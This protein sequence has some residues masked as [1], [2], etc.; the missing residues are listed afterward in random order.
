MKGLP[1]VLFDC[2][3]LLRKPETSAPAIVMSMCLSREVVAGNASWTCS[4]RMTSCMDWVEVVAE[5][6]LKNVSR[7]AVMK[8][9]ESFKGATWASKA[10]RR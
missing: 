1:G 6:C 9:E 7:L 10:V 2:L 8:A 4:W 5:R 3:P